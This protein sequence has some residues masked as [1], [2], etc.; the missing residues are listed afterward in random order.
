MCLKGV[1][2]GL[3]VNDTAWQLGNLNQLQVT[4]SGTNAINTAN[5]SQIGN[6]NTISIGQVNQNQ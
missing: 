1:D 5:V 3:V 2:S 4:Q 6:S